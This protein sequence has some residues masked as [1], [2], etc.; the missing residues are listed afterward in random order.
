MSLDLLDSHLVVLL[1]FSGLVATALAVLY[2]P[3]G[4][5]L[6]YGA[7]IFAAFTVGSFTASWL[8]AWLGR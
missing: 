3:A 7:R 1:L 6:G 4:R 8:M 5:R 2:R